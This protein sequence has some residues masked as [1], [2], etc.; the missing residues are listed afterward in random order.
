MPKRTSH[1]VCSECGHAAPK[2][3]GQCPDCGQW[4]TH[5]E[6]PVPA[7][8]AAAP[9][10]PIVLTE[11]PRPIGDIPVEV[12]DDDAHAVAC[13]AMCDGRPHAATRPCDDGDRH[14]RLF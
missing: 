7:L 6:E 4:N 10:A 5:D 13:Q 8:G 2:W 11:A 14:P 12:V 9:S 1:H 3:V